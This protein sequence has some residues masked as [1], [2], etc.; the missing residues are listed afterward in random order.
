MFA[1]GVYDRLAA[2]LAC[3]LLGVALIVV[4]RLAAAP[5]S[6][7]S[8]AA[9]WRS[10]RG[11]ARSLAPAGQEVQGAARGLRDRGRAGHD[12]A[13]A[14]P[15]RPP[16]PEEATRPLTSQTA[17]KICDLVEHYC[18]IH[19]TLEK[20]AET[21]RTEAE[22]LLFDAVR[23][24]REDFATERLLLR[25]FEKNYSFIRR[26]FLL[27]PP[28]RPIL[29]I[30]YVFFY[31]L[32]IFALY[33]CCTKGNRVEL[34]TCRYASV[35][36]RLSMRCACLPDC[37][38]VLAEEIVGY[39]SGPSFRRRAVSARRE[40]ESGSWWFKDLVIVCANRQAGAAQCADVCS[41][42]L[43]QSPS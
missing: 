38:A 26:V 7:C 15:P 41:L 34:E 39:R 43:A 10:G 40:T 20:I 14:A 13:H 31:V 12:P 9:G 35:S 3:F 18:K 33:C 22:L 2:L 21:H 1:D 23:A 37:L 5:A 16:E 11:L 28:N 25:E 27:H 19:I 30:I 4:R 36:C 17:S 42:P 29:R 6:S 32:I 24:V 8:R